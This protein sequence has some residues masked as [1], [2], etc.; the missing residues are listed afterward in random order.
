MFSVFFFLCS[1]YL[2]Q[3]FGMLSI[4]YEWVRFTVRSSVLIQ[5]VEAVNTTVLANPVD[6]FSGSWSSSS[7]DSRTKKEI[8]FAASRTFFNMSIEIHSLGPIRFASVVETKFGKA[9][10]NALCPALTFPSRKQWTLSNVLV[11]NRLLPDKCI[12]SEERAIRFS[13]LVREM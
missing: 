2:D 3:V 8:R 6:S 9:I 13:S 10:S 7:Y 4:Q 5:N 11:R 12:W 1:K